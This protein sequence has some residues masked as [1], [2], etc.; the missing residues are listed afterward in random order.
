[1]LRNLPNLITTAR[2]LLA[3]YFVWLLL[4]DRYGDALIV[5]AVMGASDAL[6]G[7]L[8]K[9]YH[10]QSR[11]GAYLDPLADKL[12]LV[13][14]YIA[15][16]W[17]G[18][19]PLWLVAIVVGRDVLILSGALAYHFVVRRLEM[20]PSAVSKA[21]TFVQIVL[22]LAVILDQIMLMPNLAL[23]TLIWLTLITTLASG[24]G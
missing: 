3:P 21:N 10:W 4:Q 22:A 17:K 20:N 2:V 5:F 14:A 13:S 23:D 12:M 7:Y 18:L 6:D 16:A 8:A 1:M 15:L 11:L 19:I 9:T 24:A